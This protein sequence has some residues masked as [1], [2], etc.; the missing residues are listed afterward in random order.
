V[1][2]I[3][4][5]I[6]FPLLSA[7]ILAITKNEVMR[8]IVV[9]VS[10]CTLAMAALFLAAQFFGNPNKYYLID[11]EIISYMILLIE[12]IVAI[13]IIYLGIRYKKYLVS[14]LSFAQT[15]AMLFFE[16]G[17][18]HSTKNISHHAFVD[19]LSIIMVLIIAII[20][21]LIC[22]FAIAY[23]RYYHEHHKEVKDRRQL[24]FS[25]IF[26]FLSAMFGIIFSNDLVWMYFF[27]E[28]TTLCSFLLIGYTQ[29]K[30]AVNNSFTALLMNLIGGV[31]FAGAILYLG[32]GLGITELK[33][34]LSASA[35]GV[36][37]VI[38]A[39]LLAVAGLS[40]AAQL[41]F[42]KWLLGAM[43]APTPVS[44]LLHSSTM[45]KAGVYLLIRISP[46]LRNNMSGYM[47][48]LVG[49]ITFLLMSFIA[50]SQNDAKKVLA[51]STI[52]NLGLIVACA[53]VGTYE[54]I[55]AAVMLIVFHAV[56]KSLMFI[57]VGATEQVLGSR[58]IEDMHGLI[59]KLPELALI[60]S[61]GIAGMFLAPFGMLI[62][63]W[64][65]L[66]AF[67]DSKNVVIV[68]MLVYGSAATLFYWTKW[69]GKLA[70]VI[71]N[72]ERLKDTVK[73]DEWIA[74]ISHAL[75][76]VVLCVMF[77]IISKNLIEPLLHDMFNVTGVNMISQGNQHIMT[78]ML[79]MII[80]L[81]FGMRF[82]TSREEKLVTVYMG[83]VNTGDNRSFEGA[84]G[85]SK[86]MY[87]SSWYMQKYFGEKKLLPAGILIG[88][89]I[90][91]T[92]LIYSIV[93]AALGG[94]L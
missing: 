30:E 94:A 73:R 44:A 63:K 8:G 53:G 91:T 31:G 17:G 87:L 11:S 5:L 43:V 64:A 3:L 46:L 10:V 4:F 47:V 6:V 45:V 74:L 65:A 42:S 59:V 35:N 60:M 56:A 79:V 22:I 32:F 1:N 9:R 38:P 20:G 49:G 88:Q 2:T 70:A 54:A 76:V 41:P 72:S 39:T 51:Y 68:I 58:D 25:I 85:G 29:T 66:K 62:S 28:I 84:I 86:R 36:N 89:A 83:G 12:I 82:L 33:D 48:I 93:F 18:N 92:A 7:L 77:P 75:L 21:G 27:W 78:M 37:L 23:M 15:A 81:P 14:F 69:L 13:Y 34:V 52:A 57:S 90:I 40:K 55:W 24:F 80:I 19:D 16:L 61:I 50:I 67:I 26:L 71:P